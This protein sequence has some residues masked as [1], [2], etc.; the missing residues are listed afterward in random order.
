MPDHNCA[1]CDEPVLPGEALAATNVLAHWE[2]GLRAVVGGVNHLRGLCSCCGGT[3]P[4]DPPGM[5][6]REAA[7][8]AVEHYRKT[9]RLVPPDRNA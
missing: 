9:H 6:R 3:E 7:R 1:F 5:T 4:P 2:C 8:A